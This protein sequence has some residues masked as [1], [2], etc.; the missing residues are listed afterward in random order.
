MSDFSKFN[1]ARKVTFSK[2]WKRYKKGQV[3]AMHK[4]VADK[5]EKAKAGKVEPIDFKAIKAKAAK[6]KK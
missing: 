3:Q 6:Y 2:D 4:S 1:D 5:V